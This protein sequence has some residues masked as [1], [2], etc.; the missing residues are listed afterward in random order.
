MA[1]RRDEDWWPTKKKPLHDDVDELED[2]EISLLEF[3]EL[4]IGEENPAYLPEN[5]RLHKK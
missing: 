3:R 1:V 4:L 2:D 5:K